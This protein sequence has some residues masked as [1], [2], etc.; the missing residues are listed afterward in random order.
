[1]DD[2]PPR[3]PPRFWIALGIF[4]SLIAVALVMLTVMT[5]RAEAQEQAPLCARMDGLMKGMEE[6]FHER[7]IWQGVK[8]TPQGP[9]E[10]FLFQSEDGKSWTQVDVVG[11]DEAGKSVGCFVA[12]GTNGVPND[13]GK[14]V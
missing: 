6:A 11:K 12:L 10:T 14:G 2:F 8:N 7:K 1:M 4:A 9:I 13:M 3:E 5:I